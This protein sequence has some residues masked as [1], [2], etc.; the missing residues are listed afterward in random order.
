MPF[1]DEIVGCLKEAGVRVDVRRI[2]L[3]F[4]SSRFPRAAQPRRCPRLSRGAQ[5]RSAPWD[6]GVSWARDESSA[7]FK[8]GRAFSC[9]VLFF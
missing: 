9:A 1:V 4:F 2:S 3:V 5:N 6:E 8:P 7:S